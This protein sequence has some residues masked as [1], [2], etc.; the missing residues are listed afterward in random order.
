MARARMS[1][2]SPY[3]TTED[4]DDDSEI[5]TAPYFPTPELAAAIPS[6]LS[7]FPHS[8]VAVEYSLN[9]PSELSVP[10]SP[11]VPSRLL[12]PT[13]QRVFTTPSPPTQPS[14]LL[15]ARSRPSLSR[16][17]TEYQ[18][19]PRS[20]GVPAGA[21]PPRP[22]LVRSASTP[23]PSATIRAQG[24]ATAQQRRVTG[25][26]PLARP[27]PIG[28]TPLRESLRRQS[29]MSDGDTSRRPSVAEHGVSVG[30]KGR[31]PSAGP[32]RSL[33][34]IRRASINA[35]SLKSDISRRTSV[36]SLTK[37]DSRKSSVVSL[38]QGSVVSLASRKSSTVSITEY[39]YLACQIVVDAPGP[40][41]VA[42]EPLSV[43]RNAPT[44][45]VLPASSFPSTAPTSPY[46]PRFNPMDSFLGR[47]TPPAL[48][49]LSPSA[50]MDKTL[51]AP[52]SGI[53]DRGRPISPS[54]SRDSFP[55]RVPSSSSPQSVAPHQSS[56]T[57][58]KKISFA[59]LDVEARRDEQVRM[60]KEA[61]NE[62]V[63]ERR[64]ATNLLDPEERAV[65]R[66]GAQHRRHIS[67][68]V[69][70]DT[71]LRRPDNR[72]QTTLPIELEQARLSQTASSP[73][74]VI[75]VNDDKKAKNRSSVAFLETPAVRPKMD[76]S[77]SASSVI[78]FFHGKSKNAATLQRS[79]IAK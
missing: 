43:R 54:D 30:Q 49:P 72:R 39:G 5:H 65:L 77:V 17:A 34:D 19:P 75:P 67:V 16:A 69:S 38:R 3:S 44:S 13:S 37:P 60:D 7:N 79:P 56:R 12:Q 33:E 74:V 28:K 76:R 55:F 71:S 50:D 58:M 42:I 25:S 70:A 51:T 29:V 52:F 27:A 14:V 46:T 59:E 11:V 8:S 40:A 41:P 10:P 22:A 62:R 66:A 68:P 45:L 15:R 4:E 53:M 61:E 9:T 21:G 23:F 20:V 78:R 1:A 24:A 47:L 73:Q 35:R 31:R 57:A 64:G 2:W 36:A 32:G 18:F 48:G 63:L 6:I 26:F